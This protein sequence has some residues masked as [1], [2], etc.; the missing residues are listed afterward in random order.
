MCK[1]LVQAVKNIENECA[2]ADR[3]SEVSELIDD[4]L[5]AAAVLRDGHI[6]LNN[7]AELGV[8]C[9]GAGLTVAKKLSFEPPP[10]EVS[11]GRTDRAVSHH[12][13]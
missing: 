13:V 3:F 1:A 9:H 7:V 12:F 6:A 11:S 5:E 2:V 8:E 10:D 4:R